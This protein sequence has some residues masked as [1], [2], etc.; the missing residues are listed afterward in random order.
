MLERLRKVPWTPLLLLA[1]LLSNCANWFE[2]RRVQ[3]KADEWGWDGHYGQSD[4]NNTLNGMNDRLKDIS[5]NAEISARN[6][7]CLKAIR[8][9]WCRP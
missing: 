1:L 7:D 6:T 4:A 2:L 9:V 3:R 5:D 8:P